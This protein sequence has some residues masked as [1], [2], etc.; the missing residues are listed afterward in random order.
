MRRQPGPRALLF[1]ARLISK[2]TS[3]FPRNGPS[4][5]GPDLEKAVQAYL[6]GK[7]SAEPGKRFE[8]FNGGYALLAAIVERSSGMPFTEYCR[9]NLFEPAGM[10]ATGF[11]QERFPDDAPLAHGYDDDREAGAA[12][13]H[14]FGWEYRGMGGVVTSV[15]DL[16]RWDRSLRDGKILEKAALEKLYT[17]FLENYACG[18]Y[19]TRTSRGTRRA[20]HGGN[21]KGFESEIIR[22]LDE[23]ATV[24][25]LANRCNVH[26]QVGYDVANFLF[27]EPFRVPPPPPTTQVAPESLRQLAGEFELSSKD[28]LVVRAE[29]GR[30]VVGADCG[31]AIRILSP[32]TDPKDKSDFKKERQLAEAVVTDLSHGDVARIREL[33]PKDAFWAG[34]WPEDLRTS[35]WPQHVETWGRLSSLREIGA[36]K[37]SDSSVRIWIRLVHEKGERAAE[38]VFS[39]GRLTVLDLHGRDFPA[40]AFYAP[41]GERRFAS[42]DF[43]RPAAPPIQFETTSDGTASRLVVA[44]PGGT[45]VTARRLERSK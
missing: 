15:M 13:S 25:V 9:K 3:G 11:C 12:N 21:V 6:G 33:I 23:D 40:S 7:R 22:F 42:Y 45:K 16:Y 28:R 31:E 37:E 19:V 27:G 4:G 38:V 32:S 36:R 20:E 34:R 30:L 2:H 44:G 10:S 1:A 26:W 5:G 24:I 29:E 35:I 39:N 43:D 8:Y 41:V 18:W 17:P 14:S